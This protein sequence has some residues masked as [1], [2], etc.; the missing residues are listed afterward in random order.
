MLTVYNLMWNGPVFEIQWNGT[1]QFSNMF[2]S[3][4]LEKEFSWSTQ[5]I[6]AKWLGEEAEMLKGERS[7]QA[8]PESLTGKLLEG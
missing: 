2:F 6:S 7:Y 8:S 1:L 5:L 4:N 3:L